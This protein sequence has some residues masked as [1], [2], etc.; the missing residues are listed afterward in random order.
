V[1]Y[2]HRARS[3]LLRSKAGGR[4]EILADVAR[5]L[6]AAVRAAGVERDCDIVVPAPSHPFSDLRR[7]FAPAREIARAVAPALGLACRPV[8]RRRLLPWGVAKGRRAVERRR[9]IRGS[10]LSR[11]RLDG[12]SVLLIDDVMTSGAT[13]Q[14]A[15]V[16]LRQA[17]CRQVVAAVWARALP[18]ELR[19]SPPSGGGTRPDAERC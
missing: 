9:L 13:A 14:A 4:P 7:G 11:R 1:E 5:Q 2:D 8:L 6:A 3:I 17:G 12:A 10:M 19:T 16:A 18:P 15:A